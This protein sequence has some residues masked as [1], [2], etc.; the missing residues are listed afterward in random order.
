[1]QTPFIIVPLTRDDFQ[2]LQDSA[3]LKLL[4]CF[5]VN[6]N[7][8]GQAHPRV[9][10]TVQREHFVEQL[11]LAYDTMH[12]LFDQDAI[13]DLTGPVDKEQVENYSFA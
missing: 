5:G 8:K 3:F 12:K 9:D 4:A 10:S 13:G 6:V 2:K 1:M 7:I 11:K